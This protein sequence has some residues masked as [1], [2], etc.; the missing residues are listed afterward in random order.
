MTN[1][2]LRI[3]NREIESL[4]EGGR[5][6]EAIAHCQH[7]L[8]TFPMNVKTYQ[9]LGKAFLE[10]RRYADAADIFQRVLMAVPDDF[11]AHVGMSIIRD[12]EC[13]VDDAI[14]HM[15]RAF[16]IQPSNPAIQGELK[17]LYGQ[18]D[19]IEPPKVR[20]TRDALANMY[21]QGELYNQAIVEIRSVMAEDANRA[22]L[23]VM[24][25]RA[26][27]RAGQKVEAAE[28]SMTLLKKYPYCLDALRILVDILPG[29][30]CAEDAQIY[31]QRVEQLDPYSAFVN[32]SVFR[33]DQV[34]DSVIT[35]ERLEYLPRGKPEAVQPEW[36]SSLG[37]KMGTGPLLGVIPAKV[38]PAKP[39]PQTQEPEQG[40]PPV[41][42]EPP[43]P[44]APGAAP[45]ESAIPE[46]LRS[47]GWQED[48]GE[49]K[50]GPSEFAEQ[51]Q[52]SE[53]IAQA[54]IP[55]WLQ[56]MA[57]EGVAAQVEAPELDLTT[58]AA[59]E[60]APE[61]TPFDEMPAEGEQAA[62]LKPPFEGVRV[63]AVYEE[64]GDTQPEWMK[65]VEAEK[66]PSTPFAETEPAAPVFGEQ[67]PPE[68]EPTTAVPGLP[69]ADDQDAA[70]AWLENLAAKQGAKPEELL[71][72]PEERLENPPE[73]VWQEAAAEKP[74]EAA[75]IE[76][77]AEKAPPSALQET[78]EAASL[79]EMPEEEIAAPILEET[80]PASF[81]PESPA[82]PFME[83][84]TLKWL[85]SLSAEENVRSEARLEAA[86]E[87][88]QEQGPAE[89]LPASKE[90]DV[91]A[92]L[93]DLESSE[94]REKTP[95]TA[96]TQPTPSAGEELPDWLKGITQPT[97]AAEPPKEEE[98][99]EWLRTSTGMPES[100]PA[101]APTLQ[102]QEAVEEAGAAIPSADE[103]IPVDAVLTP[104]APEEWLRAEK[105]EPLA[106]E[107]VSFAVEPEPETEPEPESVQPATK[108]IV[109]EQEEPAM[110]PTEPTAPAPKAAEP[111]PAAGLQGALTPM[112]VQDKDAEMLLDAQS[113]LKSG[114]LDEAMA[115]FVKL[116][117]KGR[118]LDEVI[119]ELREAVYTYPVDIIIWQTLGDAYNRANQLQD[120]LDAYT[121]AEELLR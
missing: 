38:P 10:V 92:W 30:G 81:T 111:A 25:A 24:L 110:P 98:L 97:P 108:P 94:M 73:W 43:A 46:W 35:L 49:A 75:G 85:D 3:Y 34:A 66:E 55:D 28:M 45:G 65:G 62:G 20:L 18:R 77:E 19:G 107:L 71:T 63:G 115:G 113:T 8:K 117:K 56:A 42:F 23:Q 67:K 4:I 57:P 95:P 93:K 33:S 11:V 121:K 102:E 13:K 48:T 7:I 116:I 41:S 120:A 53:P 103:D 50:E 17:R 79:P 69:S 99:P 32:D 16:E 112:P 39:A 31:R 51:P 40:Q 14:W 88:G 72:R 1:V 54:E 36:A 86:P 58:L 100:L 109:L 87:A 15:E 76:P 68:P 5:I 106:P 21:S 118:L 89:A 74:I 84:E 80:I 47:A 2:S 59:E 9:L 96:Q 70:L 52:P 60:P 27:Y 105:V 83:E 104:T 90:G 91:S 101:Q 64:V 12:D 22:D 61:V 114:K 78:T 26:Y 37:I 6:D 44:V 119:H 29:T 82:T